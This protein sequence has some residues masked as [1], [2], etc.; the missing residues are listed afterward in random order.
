MSTQPYS[1]A[2][3]LWYFKTTTVVLRYAGENVLWPCRLGAWQM[4]AS[5]V[6]SELFLNN[7]GISYL[8]FH[9]IQLIYLMCGD[10]NKLGTNPQIPMRCNDAQRHAPSYTSIMPRRCLCLSGFPLFT[11]FAMI[12]YP[13]TVYLIASIFGP[14]LFLNF[15]D[16]SISATHQLPVFSTLW[17]H[18][19]PDYSI[20]L[21]DII[22]MIFSRILCR[23][24]RCDVVGLSYLHFQ[25]SVVVTWRG[26]LVD[27]PSYYIIRFALPLNRHLRPESTHP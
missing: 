9:C 25:R 15:P 16:H 27:P 17:C 14:L 10:G 13:Y 5:T 22:L 6:S 24:K 12:R 23:Y 3:N 8:V 18:T 26:S 19:I 20:P 4:R 2:T 11:I 7:S 1:T 21:Y